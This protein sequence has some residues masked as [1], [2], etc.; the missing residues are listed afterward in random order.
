M[1][2][3]HTLFILLMLTSGNGIAREQETCA[4]TI[5]ELRDMLSDQ[6]FPLIWQE[7]SMNDNKPLM[8]SIVEINGNLALEFNKTREGLWAK[9]TTII[10]K[11][12]SNLEAHFTKDQI[13]T[14]PAANWILRYAFGRGGK[15]TLTKFG[16]DQLRITSNGWNG[17][18]LPVEK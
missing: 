12:G 5:G 6:T 13:H 14:G 9:S 11:A 17:N 1:Y 7:T 16:S 4:T 2:L 18:F 10:C 3:K 15:F 8:L